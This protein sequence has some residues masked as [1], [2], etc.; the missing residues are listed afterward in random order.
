L[1]S[2]RRSV[3]ARLLPGLAKIVRRLPPALPLACRPFLAAAISWTPG[4]RRR[5][6][7]SMAAALGPAGFQQQHVK[8]FF[9]RL[10]D[11]VAYSMVVYRCGIDAPQLRKEL[12]PD[13]ALLEA[14]RQALAEGNG[15]LLAG[16]H[17]AGGE[18]V[19]AAAA[20]EL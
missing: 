9:R 2:S 8:D 7:R 18:V 3:R 12:Y 19:A 11:M 14:Y 5:V 15:V 16:P 4:W 10:A 13:P 6:R 20:R 1:L 17:L